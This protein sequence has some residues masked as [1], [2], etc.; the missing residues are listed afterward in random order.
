LVPAGWGGEET[1]PLFSFFHCA[2]TGQK[3][4]LWFQP[5]TRSGGEKHNR[6]FL[7]SPLRACKAEKCALVPAGSG[8][9]KQNSPPSFS[10]LRARR[11]ETR[12]LVP[13]PFFWFQPG[14]G[15]KHTL[16]LIV[17]ISYLDMFLVV[18]SILVVPGIVKNVTRVQHY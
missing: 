12:A 1:Q 16:K 13:P 9:K 11:T 14:G 2:R 8:G 17:I 3:N 18:S 10:S 4:A 5:A 15:K 7:F 6:L